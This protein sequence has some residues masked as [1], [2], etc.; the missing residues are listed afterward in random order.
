MTP[1]T[2]GAEQLALAQDPARCP[3]C[4]REWPGLFLLE[5]GEQRMDLGTFMRLAPGDRLLASRCWLGEC[6][7]VESTCRAG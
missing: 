2:P 5:R 4:G 3:C 1:A 6:A 7:A